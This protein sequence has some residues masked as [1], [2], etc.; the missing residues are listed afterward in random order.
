VSLDPPQTGTRQLNRRDCFSTD[1]VAGFADTQRREVST[2]F[3]AEDRLLNG[4]DLS[5]E[6]GVQKQ[7]RPIVDTSFDEGSS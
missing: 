6:V 1:Q 4:H 3:L 2:S 5:C 7:E